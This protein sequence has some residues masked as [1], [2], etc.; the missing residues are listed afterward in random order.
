[1][2]K[3]VLSMYKL[4]EFTKPMYK[5]GE[6]KDLLG[7]TTQ[8]LHNYE[9]ESLLKF[10]RTQGG[11][12]VITK[13]ELVRYLRDRG[14]IEDDLQKEKWDVV[15][16]RVDTMSEAKLGDL[17]IQAFNVI[18]GFSED[19]KKLKIFKEVGLSTDDAR[20]QLNK[21]LDM[22]LQDE[23]KRLY[24]ESKGTIAST[25]YRYIEKLCN[26]KGVKIHTLK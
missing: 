17:D 3:A 23:V 10:E 4:S 15:Y 21:V 14:L 6:V 11:H 26:Y 8:T 19:I 9:K 22:I 12:R 1:M 13:K 24:V 25:G 5:I 20:K 16:A 2:Q 7:V 18:E